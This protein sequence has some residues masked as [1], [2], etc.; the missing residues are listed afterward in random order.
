MLTKKRLSLLSLMVLIV[1][2]GFY[3]WSPDR[4]ITQVMLEGDLKQVKQHQLDEVLEPFLGQSFWEVDLS[5]VHAKVVRLDWVYKATVVRRWPDKLRIEVIEQKPV[6]RW[7]DSALLNHV[8][9]IFYP[10]NIDV[11]QQLVTLEGS[12]AS[13]K[14]VLIRFQQLQQAFD[15]LKWSIVKLSVSSGK[16]WQIDFA[17]GRQM[18]LDD[19]SW[20]AKI[21]RFIRAYGAVKPA[22]RKFA[23]VYDLRYSNGFVIKQNKPANNPE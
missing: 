2:L 5:Q 4:K 14:Q 22:L 7:G 20:Q 15:S 3:V 12:D 9:E 17:S 6:A 10:Y 1:A 23:Q 8:G 19:V 11:F 21:A 16:V 18:L 13:A